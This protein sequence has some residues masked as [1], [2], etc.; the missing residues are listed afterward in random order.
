ML[1]SRFPGLLISSRAQ[2]NSAST[3]SPVERL[4]AGSA[5]TGGML[6]GAPGSGPR[7]GGGAALRGAEGGERRAALGQHQRGA[8]RG[9]GSRSAGCRWYC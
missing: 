8:C 4:G 6:A 2:S 3:D 9:A 1:A 7:G 5:R